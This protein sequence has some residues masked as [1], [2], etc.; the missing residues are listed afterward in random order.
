M[1]Q[2]VTFA[3]MVYGIGAVI[4]F[5]VVLMIKGIFGLLKVFSS[6]KSTN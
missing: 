4:S 1:D 3:L 6:K 2:S 5:L